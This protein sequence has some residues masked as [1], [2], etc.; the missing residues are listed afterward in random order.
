M[1]ADKYIRYD[2]PGVEHGAGAE[3]DALIAEVCA[4]INEAQTRVHDAHHHA[5]SGTHVKTH[6]VV[7]GTLEVL[8]NLPPHLAQS[9]FA[10][11]GTYPVGVRFS[12]E[13]VDLV[14]D[15]ER[16]P[17]GM[18]FKVFNVDGEKL[19]QDGKDPRT[20]VRRPAGVPRPSL[21]ANASVAGL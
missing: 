1:T 21:S 11:P 17:R 9:M 2:A 6:G 5:F 16:A 15:T 19:R 10:K 12:S 3:E 8:P 4:Q 13:P 18:A 20:Q 7:K 14:P